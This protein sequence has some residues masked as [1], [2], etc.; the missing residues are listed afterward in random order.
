VLVAATAHYS[1]EKIVRALGIGG[2]QLQFVPVDAHCRM[3]PDALWAQ[4]VRHAKERIPVLALVSV[5]GTTE[6]SAVDRLDLIAD[7]RDRAQKELGISF[8]L[9]SDACYGGYAATVTWKRDGTR[10][11]A[12]EI[13]A[14]TG[15]AWPE[16]G[17]VEAM[18]ALGR[19][20][21][22]SIDPHKL[23]YVPYAAGAFLLRDRRARELVALD[24]PY[25]LPSASA[26]PSD[27]RFLGRYSLEGSRP[28]AAAAATWL[29]HKVV[30]LHEDGYGHLIERTVVGAQRLHRALAAADLAGCKAVMLPLPDINIV[31][32]TVRAPG[33]RSFTEV[34]AFNE[35]LYRHLSGSPGHLPPPYFVTRTR[36]TTPTY[37]GAMATLLNTLDVGSIE[38]WRRGPEGLVVLRMTVMD[39]WHAD[40][41]PAPDHVTGFVAHLA[42]LCRTFTSEK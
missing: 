16:P 25:L 37:D 11:N 7:V 15:I 42:E 40:G 34:N 1:W 39:P 3:D 17:W 8:H 12:R 33:H 23:G 6:E 26:A 30:P 19:T 36:L 4:L 31:N 32:F 22:V 35:R 2:R 13:Q 9:H 28:G 18:L 41:P 10:R 21:S 5:C 20:D 14:S 27:E 24:P 38:D 29:S